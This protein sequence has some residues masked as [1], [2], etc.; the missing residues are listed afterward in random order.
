[1]SEGW[2]LGIGW[3]IFLAMLAALAITVLRRRS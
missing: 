3:M 1:M 2:A